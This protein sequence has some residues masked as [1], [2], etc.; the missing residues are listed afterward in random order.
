MN[1]IVTVGVLEDC[2]DFEASK[3]LETDDLVWSD[4]PEFS[5]IL[6]SHIWFLNI[7]SLCQVD[8]LISFGWVL[9]E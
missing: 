2:C 3:V 4:S 8:G 1:N 7:D 6:K 5:M 9:R